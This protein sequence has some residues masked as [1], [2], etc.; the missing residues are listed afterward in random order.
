MKLTALTVVEI[1][2]KIRKVIN[3]LMTEISESLLFITTYALSFPVSQ[4]WTPVVGQG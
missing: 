1:V 2:E 4:R 3:L